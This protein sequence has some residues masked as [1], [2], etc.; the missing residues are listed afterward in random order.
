MLLVVRVAVVVGLWGEYYVSA[1]IPHKFQVFPP[2]NVGVVLKRLL[3]ERW[4]EC[5][6]LTGDVAERVARAVI[7]MYPAAMS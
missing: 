6:G 4:G 5:A 2:Q 1:S 3:Q 7:R